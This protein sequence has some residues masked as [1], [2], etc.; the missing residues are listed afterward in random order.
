MLFI[1]HLFHHLD[2]HNMFIAQKRTYSLPWYQTNTKTYSAGGTPFY[3]DEPPS[4]VDRAFYDSETTSLVTSA[5]L[6]QRKTYFS[7]FGSNT[8]GYC[9][10]GMTSLSYIPS[11]NADK[12]TYSNDT[13]TAQASANLPEATSDHRGTGN[14]LA[15]YSY[16]GSSGETT[17][18]KTTAYKTTFSNDTTST[19]TSANL[20]TARG[21]GTVLST[22]TSALYFGGYKNTPVSFSL[23][24]TADKMP[25]T[26]D[27]TSANG[28]LT[29]PYALAAGGNG[30]MTA[31]LSK[32]GYLPSGAPDP[33]Q[34]TIYWM[35][36]NY[37]TDSVSTT[38][39]NFPTI[40]TST[41]ARRVTSYSSHSSRTTGYTMGG[42]VNRVDFQPETTRAY[43]MPF[44]TEAVSAV[45]AMN[46]TYAS[47]GCGGLG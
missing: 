7:C 11:L 10:G 34:P 28:S 45:T 1:A 46:K 23:Q 2:Q 36:V 38:S 18:D 43:K 32:C 29:L 15:M 33:G 47:T 19:Q 39:A 35:K 37:Q 24:T 6:T 21:Q 27:T 8:K 31:E 4:R 30:S 5:N 25:F 16:G 14:S 20:S 26:T 44:S 12:I 3:V 42:Y 9:I 22:Q 13:T 17:Y 41:G 40:S